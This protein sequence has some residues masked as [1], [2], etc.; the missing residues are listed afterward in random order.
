MIF[1]L[2]C[3]AESHRELVKTQITRPFPKVCDPVGLV[4][5]P[6]IC[7]SNMLPDVDASS[8]RVTLR[9]T[10]QWY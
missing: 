6:R 2:C 8:L 3:I 10:V 4:W 1:E 7:I 5:S 9:N